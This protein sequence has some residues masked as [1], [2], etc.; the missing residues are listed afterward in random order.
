MKHIPQIIK[1]TTR[2]L[3]NNSTKAEIILWNHM[4]QE[5]LGIRFLRQKPVYVFTE[6]N[7]LDRF[8]IVDFYCAEKKCIIEL[9]GGIH[10]NKEVYD[11]D[12]E[13][14]ELLQNK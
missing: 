11:L 7:G 9:D 10:N 6:D 3:R 14:E 12:R 1:Q 4:K 2:E 13:K 8:I 5:K